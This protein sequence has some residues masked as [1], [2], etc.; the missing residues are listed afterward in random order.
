MTTIITS[1]PCDRIRRSCGYSDPWARAAPPGARWTVL[2]LLPAWVDLHTFWQRVEQSAHESKAEGVD[3]AVLVGK[4][5]ELPPIK[6][7]AIVDL[8]E[9]QRARD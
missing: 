2:I 6:I 5:R 3:I 8:A 7:A 4:L 9:R 1:R